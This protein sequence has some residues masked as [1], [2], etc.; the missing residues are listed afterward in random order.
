MIVHFQNEKIIGLH[1]WSFYSEKSWN[2]TVTIKHLWFWFFD[3]FVLE[4]T[5]SFQKSCCK[6][7]NVH[8][9]YKTKSLVWKCITEM[10]ID[11]LN[12]KQNSFTEL[13][14]FNNFVLK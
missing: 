6:M 1:F 4:K 9:F 2:G 13:Y 3:N 12:D 10:I 5:K 8:L 14:T 7:I 11:F